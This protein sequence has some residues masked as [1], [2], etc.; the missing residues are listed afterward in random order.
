MASTRSSALTPCSS[1]QKRLILFRLDSGIEKLSVRSPQQ[2]LTSPCFVLSPL[3][4]HIL[5]VSPVPSSTAT[6]RHPPCVEEKRP[7][8]T[9]LPGGVLDA[10]TF[11]QALLSPVVDLDHCVVRIQSLFPCILYRSSSAFLIPSLSACSPSSIT[12]QRNPFQLS[13]INCKMT[14]LKRSQRYE[15]FK[16]CLG[17]LLNQNK[18]VRS[19]PMV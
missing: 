13:S 1:S 3:G 18:F 5:P 12:E 11:P 4:G 9:T 19:A 2:L 17:G 10:H 16:T 7:R 8:H 15:S 6:T 14:W